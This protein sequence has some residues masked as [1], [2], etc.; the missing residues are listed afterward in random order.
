MFTY[1]YVPK[2]SLQWFIWLALFKPKVLTCGQVDLPL[3][4][5]CYHLLICC[6]YVIT[7]HLY[8]INGIC[9]KTCA[10]YSAM[11]FTHSIYWSRVGVAEEIC[12][13]LLYNHFASCQIMSYFSHDID[14]EL[15]RHI[16]AKSKFRVLPNHSSVNQGYFYFLIHFD[17]NLE[18]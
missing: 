1:S 5:V 14:R 8:V 9:C 18:F 13:K 15:L 10:I 11:I 16:L 6:L 2:M 3:Y 12:I 4:F 17:K 7:H